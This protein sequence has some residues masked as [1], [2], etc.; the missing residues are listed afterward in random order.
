MICETSLS[1]EVNRLF[2]HWRAAAAVCPAGLGIGLGQDL[3]GIPAPSD[4]LSDLGRPVNFSLFSHPSM[5][6]KVLTLEGCG[7]F[8][9]NQ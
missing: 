6:T 8:H 9:I 2:R 7:S 3:S 1:N 4:P 5:K